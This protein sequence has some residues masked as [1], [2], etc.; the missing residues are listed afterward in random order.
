MG[1]FDMFRKKDI[2]AEEHSQSEDHSQQEENELEGMT[3][4]DIFRMFFEQKAAQAA[5]VDFASGA[6]FDLSRVFRSHFIEAV[7]AND[8]IALHKAFAGA[9]IMFLEHPEVIGVFPDMVNKENNDT[10]PGRWNTDVFRL[11]TGDYA[12]LLFM[13]VQDDEV[14]ARIV[15]IIFNDDGDG[16]YYCMLNK[17]TG[18]L[19][20]VHRNKA[21][22]GIETVGAVKGVGFELMNDFL[23]CIT[24]DFYRI[25]DRD[26][27]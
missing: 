6:V 20:E 24:E 14:M 1:F 21:W 22:G 17:D 15:G 3:K 11:K 23:N 12:A 9:Y 16:Y 25:L 26:I 18:T 27:F 8:A 2:P 10:D 7:R 4:E 5:S 13:P 19:S